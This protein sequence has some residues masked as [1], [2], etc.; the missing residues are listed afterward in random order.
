MANIWR[1][2]IF[3]RT[4]SDV[5]FAIMKISE[6]KQNHTHAADIEVDDEKIVIN[7]GEVVTNEDSVELKTDGL[8]YVEDDTLVAQFGAVYDLKGCLNLSDIT[9]IEDNIEYLSSQLKAYKSPTIIHCKEWSKNGLPTA[10]DM[11]RIGANIRSLFTGYYTPSGATEVPYLIL[12]YEDINALEHNLY[13]LKELLDAMKGSFVIS[14]TQKCGTAMR[15]PI[16][17]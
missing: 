5:A 13:L 14:G 9:R 16:R 11:E 3:D 15:L 10:M 7:E 6:W 4:S 17:R 12:S 8:A 1:K 2:P